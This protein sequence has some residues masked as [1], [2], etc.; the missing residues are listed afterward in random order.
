MLRRDESTTLVAAFLVLAT[1]LLQPLIPCHSARYIR[2]SLLLRHSLGF[3][4]MLFFFANI[5]RDLDDPRLLALTGATYGGFLVMSRLSAAW[6]VAL[7]LLLAAMYLVHL[8]AIRNVDV[9]TKW[10]DE[11]WPIDWVQPVLQ[12]TAA[13]VTVVGFLV[14]VG[15]KKLKMGESFNYADLLFGADGC[16]VPTT[17]PDWT[18]ALTAAFTDALADTRQKGGMQEEPDVLLLPASETPHPFEF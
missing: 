4:V 16:G 18:R 12:G 5:T 11:G 13:L 1:T 3:L 2:D 15:E 14:Y 6:W 9:V 10:A 7:I 8:F 17:T